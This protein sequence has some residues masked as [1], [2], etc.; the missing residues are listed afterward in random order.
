M[1]SLNRTTRTSWG[2]ATAVRIMNITFVVTATNFLIVRCV[3][4][5]CHMQLRSQTMNT[6]GLAA[7]NEAT[8]MYWRLHTSIVLCCTYEYAVY[9]YYVCMSVKGALIRNP[10]QHFNYTRII[11]S[12]TLQ[13]T[14]CK[15]IHIWQWVVSNRDGSSEVTYGCGRVYHVLFS[16]LISMLVLDI[17]QIPMACIALIAPLWLRAWWYEKKWRSRRKSWIQKKIYLEEWKDWEKV[18][19]EDEGREMKND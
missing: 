1:N 19:I 4:I 3:Q 5:V 2:T 15:C 6:V 17:L 10:N 7:S 18:S 13:K 14:L 16:G 12:I 11:R 8:Y 9:I